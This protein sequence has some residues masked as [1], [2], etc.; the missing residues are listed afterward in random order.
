MGISVS[1][2]RLTTVRW[3]VE[4]NTRHGVKAYIQKLNYIHNNPVK[5]GSA[6]CL[7]NTNTHRH[8]FFIPELTIRD[9]SLIIAISDC[10][11][12]G[13]GKHPPGRKRKHHAKD[14][15]LPFQSKAAGIESEYFFERIRK[16]AEIIVT[17]MEG[18][19]GNIHHPLF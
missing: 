10:S 5:A 3:R 11:V 6:N 14:T 7:K 18:D 8:C 13:G 15:Y 1:S 9:F 12:A 4:E 16:T 19:F 2:S 17:D